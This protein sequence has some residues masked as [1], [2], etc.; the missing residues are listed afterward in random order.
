MTWKC[1]VA[2]LAAVGFF[3]FVELASPVQARADEDA[4]DEVVEEADQSREHSQSNDHSSEKLSADDQPKQFST[5]KSFQDALDN[6]NQET[7]IGKK[8]VADLSRE[9]EA[10]LNRQA[11]ESLNACDF[12]ESEKI[13]I[14]FAAFKGRVYA[15]TVTAKGSL[16]KQAL[17]VDR[18]TRRYRVPVREKHD[19][20]HFA[21]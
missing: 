13:K 21:F 18:N 16:S 9:E 19:F 7:E 1:I 4:S 8:Q 6:S 12:P 15:S 10:A 17:C 11:A 20:V 14:E 5:G 2:G 3:V